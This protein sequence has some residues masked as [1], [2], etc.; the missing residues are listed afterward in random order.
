[1]SFFEPLPEPEPRASRRE[2]EAAW[3]APEWQEPAR[4]I[5]GADVRC[6]QTL[7]HDD[8]LCLRLDRVLAYPN[9]LTLDLELRVAKPP[10]VAGKEVSVRHPWALVD[11]RGR[12]DEIPSRADDYMRFGV[13]LSD[14]RRVATGTFE[15]DRLR[16]S[17]VA[18]GAAD[19]VV[20][21]YQGGTGSA[22]L[23][24]ARLWL[25]PLPPSGPVTL[26]LEWPSLQITERSFEIPGAALQEAAPQILDLWPD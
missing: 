17:A 5:V 8:R 7:F 15:Q 10:L 3:V 21:R 26:F 4:G 23:H 20:L 12:P 9:G 25:W 16:L 14:G 6:A 22:W 24:T 1:M 13:R 2:R 19:V 11:D 18:G